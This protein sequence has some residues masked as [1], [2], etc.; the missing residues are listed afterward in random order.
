MRCP[1][2]WLVA[3]LQGRAGDLVRTTTVDSHLRR[4][5]YVCIT[6]DASPFGLGA[7]LEIDGQIVS[8]FASSL[9]PTDRSTLTLQADPSSSDQQVLEALGMLVALRVW[10][11]H[12]R[13]SRVQ[14]AVRTDNVVTLTMVTKMQPHS[15]RLGHENAS[16]LHPADCVQHGITVGRIVP[17][18]H[19]RVTES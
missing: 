9:S 14:L 16:W 7:V 13:D 5:P 10:S 3:F 11:M 6:T 18:R 12:W 8:W 19:C 17:D 15:V 1:I 2:R 4:G